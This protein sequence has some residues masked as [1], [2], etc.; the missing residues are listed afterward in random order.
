M[1][2]HSKNPK[3]SRLIVGNNGLQT[4]KIGP[5]VLPNTVFLAPMAGITDYPFRCLA[6]SCGAGLVVSEMIA[7]QALIRNSSRSIRMASTAEKEF[8]LAVQISGSDPVVM[9]EAARINESLGAAIIDIN[10]GCPQRK[11]VK[12]GAGANLM[13]DEVLA[14][15]VI[16]AIVNAVGVSV[17]VK[18]RLGWNHKSINATRIAKIAQDSGASLVTVHG[19]TRSQMFSGKADWSA[20]KEVKEAVSIPVIANGDIHSPKDA[21]LCIEVSGADGI[22]IGRGALGRPWLFDQILHFLGTG[23][24]KRPPGLE[25]Q[26]AIAIKHFE[27][28]VD[29]YG[30]PVGLWL[31]RKHLAWHTKGLH[32]SALFRKSL[33]NTK[34]FNEVR[35]L[36]RRFYEAILTTPTSSGS[37]DSDGSA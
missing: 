21:S 17:T 18:I 22:M 23:E 8:P 3:C 25:E 13:R 24:D 31:S 12:T 35:D 20:I 9:A 1:T 19:R 5:A 33:N 30:L 36:L 6:R 11:I 14:G 15:K 2:I 10:M 16:E 37:P 27:H 34:S 29:F 32:G 28:I 7:S 26:Y 4:I